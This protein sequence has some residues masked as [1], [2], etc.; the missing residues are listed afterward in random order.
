L[1]IRPSVFIRRRLASCVRQST[2]LWICIRSITS[3]RSSWAERR[4]CS[5]PRSRPVVHTLV[6]RKA[7]GRAA[8]SANKSPVTAS[9]RP[10]IGELSITRPP[11]SSSARRTSRGG[12]LAAGAGADIE[13]LLRAEPDDR[14]G[15]A[16]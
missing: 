14:Q 16:G 4:I 6:A 13:H 9:A 12:C 5:M 8:S 15:F 10:Y 3:A 2:R 11:A 1:R 7:R